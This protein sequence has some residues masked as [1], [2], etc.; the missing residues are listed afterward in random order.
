MGS[1]S[2]AA[3]FLNEHSV[4]GIPLDR[5]ALAFLAILVAVALRKILHSVLA[6][7]FRRL[8]QRTATELDD[9]LL[10][11]ME[12]PVGFG[13]IIIGLFAAIVIL[14][15]PTEPTNVRRFCYTLLKVLVT[16]DI[17]WLFMRLIDVLA[18]YMMTLAGK[19]DSK[20]DDQ[21]I[22]IVRKSM[23]LF[24]GVI[25]FVL[26]I[27]N[28]GYS[29]GSLLAGLGIGGLALALAAQDTLSNFFGSV[30]I[31]LD[32]P[33]AIGDWIEGD[34]FEG[35][36]EE[37]GIRSTRIRTFGKTVISIPNSVLANSVVN[38]WSRMPIRRVKMTVGVTYDT[39]ADQMEKA[40]EGIRELLKMHPAVHQGFFLVNF[41][42]YGASSLYIFI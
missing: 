1:I 38:N 35:V 11:A 3:S 9:K 2:D 14:Q 4:V 41:T 18:E 24:V 21:L 13:L 25:V 6:V 33:F 30:T 15:L 34:D 40:V 39:K 32:R 36:V 10:E 12:K 8:T 27:Q 28:M 20:L 31:L 37:I 22:P 23:K 17:A 16:V 42:D 5:L 26:I 19:T 7:W 29:V